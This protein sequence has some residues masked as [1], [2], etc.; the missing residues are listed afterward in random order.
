MQNIVEQQRSPFSP[1]APAGLWTCYPHFGTRRP[2]PI[3]F[4]CSCVAAIDLK[5]TFFSLKIR[6]KKNVCETFKSFS[7][8]HA[9]ETTDRHNTLSKEIT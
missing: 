6:H 7:V 5:I 8:S 1:E 2:V 4:C 9:F 3:L